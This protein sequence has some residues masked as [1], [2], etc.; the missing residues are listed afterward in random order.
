M[1]WQVHAFDVYMYVD[2]CWLESGVDTRYVLSQIDLYASIQSHV[3]LSW[4]HH[5]LPG[6]KN[7]PI[8]QNVVLILRDLF[9][10]S[11]FYVLN[12]INEQRPIMFNA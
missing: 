11:L 10:I 9:D 12:E 1:G 3:Y 7:L 5:S 4:F 8:F 2:I 6:N